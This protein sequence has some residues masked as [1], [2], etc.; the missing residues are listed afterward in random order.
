MIGE[1]GAGK[2]TLMKVLNGL[3]RLTRGISGSTEREIH[4]ENPASALK[5]GIAMIYQELNPVRDMTVAENIFLGREFTRG[6]G[7]FVDRKKGEEEAEV[8]LKKFELDIR[9]GAKMRGLS[10]AKMQMIE[11]VKAV[12]SGAKLIV[13]DEPTSSLTDDEIR[14]LFKKILELKGTGFDRIHITPHGRNI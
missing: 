9:P 1:N 2:S 14:V 6:K 13:M 12:S 3:P 4:V 5:K 7:I 10:L 11:I 8:L